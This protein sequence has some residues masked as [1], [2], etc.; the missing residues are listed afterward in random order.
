MALTQAPMLA[1]HLPYLSEITAMMMLIHTKMSP[2]MI[3]QSV[4]TSPWPLGLRK[5]ELMLAIVTTASDPPIQKGLAIQYWMDVSEAASLP[6][7][8]RT[9]V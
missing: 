3:D 7:A 6:Y 8:I 2:M 4:P 9:H 1:A 5:K